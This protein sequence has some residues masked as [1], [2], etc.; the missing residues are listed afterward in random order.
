MATVLIHAGA[1]NGFIQAACAGRKFTSAVAADYAVA[2]LNLAVNAAAFGAL[3]V[4]AAGAITFA[5][6]DSTYTEGLVQ[7]VASGMLDGVELGIGT[8]TT[9]IT[10]A[11]TAI[12]AA[13]AAAAKACVAAP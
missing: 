6:A 10:T 1:T 2:P 12:A 8:N 11:L 7:S 4:T 13:V 3:V 9:A 5:D